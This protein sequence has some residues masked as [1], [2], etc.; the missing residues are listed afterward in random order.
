MSGAELLDDICAVLRRYMIVPRYA[1]EAIALWIMHA[2][3]IDASEISPILI[4]V[5][6]TKQCG[7]STLM[8]VIYWVTPRSELISNATASPIF[9]LIEDAKPK[10]PTFLLDE[11]DTF[12]T[13]EKEDLRGILNS[14]WMRAGARVIRT[15]GDGNKRRAKRFS[16]WAPKV[17]A[18]IKAVADTLMD[19]GVIIMLRRKARGETVERF[20]MRDTDEF[21][22]LRQRCQRWANDNLKGLRD[23]D[24]DIPEALTNRPADNW[25]PLL[26]IADA[27]GGDWPARAR[28]AALGLTGARDDDD[29]GVMLLRDIRRVFE[30]ART[31]WMG[32]EALT[33]KLVTLP[34]TPWAEWRRGEKPISSRGV[35]FLLK[36][37]EIESD[38]SQRPR[39]YLRRDFEQAWDSYLFGQGGDSSGSSG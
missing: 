15:E 8:T 27:V 34:E 24:P 33:E 36:P 26:A 38:D 17:I 2:W 29:K 11:G 31:E 32:A 22:Q 18:T 20:R 25:R 6:P 1:V 16:T 5:S 21:G 35:A 37:F 28:Q 12:I 13:P 14:G 10:V 39:R 4:I 30:E 3:T 23:A 7:K 19:R 9:R